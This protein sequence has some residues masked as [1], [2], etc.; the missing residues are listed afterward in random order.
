MAH[1]RQRGGRDAVIGQV[2]HA[3][4]PASNGFPHSCKESFERSD[5]RSLY[6]AL[7]YGYLLSTILRVWR[8]ADA[9]GL[10]VMCMRVAVA[11]MTSH[12]ASAPRDASMSFA[13]RRGY[14]E[15]G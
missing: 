2:R 10:A 15:K 4:D 1:S 9:Y 7:L 6:R 13:S 8:K 12:L 11:E 5:R 14:T 3:L